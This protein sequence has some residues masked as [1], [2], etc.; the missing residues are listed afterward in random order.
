VAPGIVAAVPGAGGPEPSDDLPRPTPPA[1]TVTTPDGARIAYYDFGGIGPPL[2][3]AH[4]TG[5]CGPVFGP[6]AAL[7]GARFRCLALDLCGHGASGPFRR[8]D[9]QW[10]GFAGDVLAVLDHV[11]LEG[12]FGF[13]H[14]CG[15]AALLLAE[16]ARPGTFAGLY[17][18]EPV[19]YPGDEPLEPT[20]E[21]NPLAAGALRRRQHF[22]S[23]REA[24]AN[25]SG[26][27]PFDRLL[28]EVL[29]AY[30]DNGFAPGDGGG[31]RLRCRREDE[32]QVFAH[33]FS[34]DAYAHLAEVRCPVTLA[35]GADTDGF[36][37]DLLGA[38][39]RR[40][41]AP[42]VVVLPGLGHFGPLEDPAV[43][44]ASVQASL[45][46]RTGTPGA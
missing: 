31:I 21:G 10:H 2:L 26:K 1:G 38:F 46:P 35:C 14:S 11:G 32:A 30:V 5:F 44:A 33:A 4:A 43:V 25:F 34:H 15:G 27:A 13:G 6:L 36:G 12:A 9:F 23:R 8:G 19:I 16:E 3:L 29:A 37:P 39:A 18:F 20:I 24:I 41:V 17:C 45:V 22:G 7:L 42:A 28:P 40:L